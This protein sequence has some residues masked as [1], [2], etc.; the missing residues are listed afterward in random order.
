MSDEDRIDVNDL[1][2]KIDKDENLNL[3][4]ILSKVWDGKFF[5]LKCGFISALIGVVVALV[6]ITEYSSTSILFPEYSESS[7][8]SN[9]LGQFGG[10][11]SFAGIDIGS[12]GGL[13]PELYPTIVRSTPFY[14]ELLKSKVYYKKL[15][16]SI[17]LETYM[18]DHA[19][20]SFGGLLLK[21]TIGLP[22]YLASKDKVE[23]T[24]ISNEDLLYLDK[25]TTDIIKS[26][27]DRIACEI[28]KKS[29][30]ITI[31][32]EM[33]DP[34]IAAGVNKF[35]R[36]Y[37]E[38]YL[39]D[40]KIGK[41]NDNLS[42][43]IDRREEAWMEYSDAQNALYKFRDN[44]FNITTSLA[45]SR[46]EHLEAEYTLA[47]S[48]LEELNKQVEQARIK[49]K[50]QTPVFKELQPPLIPNEKSKPKRMLTVLIFSVVGVFGG[51]AY[52]FFGHSLT[53]SED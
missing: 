47:L 15:N 7:G 5:L 24:N 52:V 25:E 17:P 46:E 32:V 29:G 23:S 20:K 6:S 39:T 40:Y 16:D 26:L 30:L 9:L 48:V 21:Y 13:N 36:A 42:F 44:N 2:L 12:E 31:Y 33:P 22:R 8:G 3:K 37:M 28:S 14:M 19:P 27:R 11:A 1:V 35:T 51:L 45:R 4:L 41:L 49:V 34:L 38:E 50:E 10:L 53:T 18:K 43:L